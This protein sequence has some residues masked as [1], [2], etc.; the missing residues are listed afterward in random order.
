MF[1]KLLALS[2]VFIGALTLSACNPDTGLTTEEILTQ[3]QEAVD[4]LSL[5]AQTSANLTLPNSEVHDVTIT[6]ASSNTD[7]ISNAG[8]I[9]APTK[10]QGNKTVTMTATLSLEDQQLVKTFSVIVLAAT[11][12]ND[13]EKVAADKADVFVQEGPTFA[14]V[15]LATT[16]ANGTTITWASSNAAVISTAGVITRPASDAAEVTVTLNVLDP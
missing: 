13:T 4:N 12:L 9:T 10:T 8:V 14:D 1:K 15:T 2:L 7:F 5:P 3:I 16:G 11:A 6:W